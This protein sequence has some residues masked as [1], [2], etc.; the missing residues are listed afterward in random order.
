MVVNFCGDQIFVDFV[1]FLIH[2]NY[3]VL[4]TR[5][6]RY[7]IFSAWFLDIRISTC[8]TVVWKYFIVKKFS[9]VMEPTKIYYMHEQFLTRIINK[10][11]NEASFI[12]AHITLEYFN[13]ERE[14]KF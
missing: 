12:H 2:D 3:E 10:V 1:S 9:W 7:N 14:N 4:Y 8:Y 13:F 11:C 6:L 5:C